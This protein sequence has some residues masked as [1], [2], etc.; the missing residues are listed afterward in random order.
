MGLASRGRWDNKA[1]EYFRIMKLDGE[2]AAAAYRN[3]FRNAPEFDRA[4]NRL[5]ARVVR[6]RETNAHLD[7]PNTGSGPSDGG[8]I[9]EVRAEV[10][11]A[12]AG[13]PVCEPSRLPEVE[14]PAA[15]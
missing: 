11:V 15:S 10:P 4:V 1:V 14:H 5:M 6:Y 3:E 2:P 9:H 8:A 7:E 13:T 12:D